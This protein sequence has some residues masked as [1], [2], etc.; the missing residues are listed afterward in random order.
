MKED[1]RQF[2]VLLGRPPARLT[3]EQAAW[4]LNCAAHDVPV[5]VAARLLKPLGSPQPNSTKLFATAELL[6]AATDRA[7]LARVTQTL[8][9]YWRGKNGRKA[10]RIVDF[11]SDSTR[12]NAALR[13]TIRA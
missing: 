1:Q 9:Q 4:L 5:L 8:Q 6:E 13:R 10:S 12:T 7:W 2:L 3:A 11:P